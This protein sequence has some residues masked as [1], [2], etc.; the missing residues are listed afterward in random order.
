MKYGLIPSPYSD[1]ALA[2][3]GSLTVSFRHL[4]ASAGSVIDTEVGDSL[5]ITGEVQ[6][7]CT[8]GDGTS[9]I[10]QVID[11]SFTKKTANTSGGWDRVIL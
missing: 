4:N 10:S 8:Y 6:Y 2:G 1:P 9:S 7:A 11:Y 5:Q 3:W